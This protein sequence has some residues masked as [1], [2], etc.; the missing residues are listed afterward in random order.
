[1]RTI[2]RI[3]P[4]LAALLLL[5]GC[6]GTPTRPLPAASG[7]SLDRFL[8]RW[9]VIA[10]V[11]YFAERG[12][13]APYV[14]YRKRAD[15]RL[16][17]LYY[18]KKS[19]KDVGYDHWSGVAWLPDRADPARWKVRFIWPFTSDYTILA[20]APDY[21]WAMVGLPSRDLLWIFAR[22]PTLDAATRDALLAKARSLGFDVS[23]VRRIPQFPDQLGKPRFQ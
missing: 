9:Y 20:V 16:D 22:Q 18:F 5:A 21:S 2:A 12:K 19:F 4:L 7:V 3:A 10:N 6:A 17:D 1:M 14:I 11:P 23:R 8:G 15:G 13:V